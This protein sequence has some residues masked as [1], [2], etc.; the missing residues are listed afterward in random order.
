MND[1]KTIS[2]LPSPSVGGLSLYLSQIKKFPMLDAEEEYMLAKNW[3]ENGNL[4]SAHKLVT[5][6]LRLVA[7]IAMGYRGYGL[8]VSELI[9]EGNIGLM[10][11][12]KKFDPNKGFR[13]A[14]YAM[15][16]IK[17]SIQEYVLKS[18]SLV[19]MGTTTAQK[20]LFFNLKKLKNQIAPGQEGDLR[21][22][23]VAEISKRLDVN[24][25]EV[26][27]MNRRMM[28]REKS[29]NDPI[30]SGE[31]DEWQDWLVDTSLDQE[32]I[33]SQKQEYEDKKGLLVDAMKILNERE[34][35][36]INER[37]LSENPKTLEE[38]SKRYKISRERI[39]QIETKAF[40]KLQKS[41]INASKA[42]NLLPAN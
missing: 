4:Q 25:Q 34:K 40:E 27:N 29:L 13:L 10:Q 33:V 19:K 15:W 23:Q 16:W 38:L 22:E 2:N 5:S 32:L 30:K 31:T 39:R 41:M 12:V 42:K 36:I 20:K 3:R 6:H 35:A 9:S 26:V 8:P 14:T 28:G 17:A 18:W 21:N 7:K 37:R 11:A 24:S 1:K